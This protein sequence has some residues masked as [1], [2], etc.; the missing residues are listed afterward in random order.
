MCIAALN[1]TLKSLVLT[2]FSVTSVVLTNEVLLVI[3]K[4]LVAGLQPPEFE[5]EV[6][7]QLQMRGDRMDNQRKYLIWCGRWPSNGARWRW[8]I[9][10][11]T[12]HVLVG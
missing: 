6:E 8:L 2:A 7:H 1:S 11:G 10:S 5:L 3:S 9:S 12:K 4:A